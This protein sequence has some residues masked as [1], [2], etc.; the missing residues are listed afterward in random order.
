MHAP[1]WT[2]L[3]EAFSIH[4]GNREILHLCLHACTFIRDVMYGRQTL[5]RIQLLR[6]SLFLCNAQCACMLRRKIILP[7]LPMGNRRGMW[8]G[9]KPTCDI[10]SADEELGAIVGEEGLVAAAL[11]LAQHIQLRLKA[12][13]CVHAAGSAEHLSAHS[14]GVKPESIR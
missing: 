2:S 3:S 1:T 14:S 7:S 6:M 8:E 11:L 12:A 9:R 5:T 10:S 13:A 4:A